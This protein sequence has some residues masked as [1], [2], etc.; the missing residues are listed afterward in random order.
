MRV[1]GGIADY[2]GFDPT[3]VRLVG[4]AV[5]L[6]TGFFPG[7]IFYIAA[8]VIMPESDGRSGAIDGDFNKK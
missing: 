6:F 2:L 1:F 3:I 7:A 5:I 8:A 4:L